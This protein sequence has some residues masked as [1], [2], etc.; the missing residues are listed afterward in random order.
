MFSAAKQILLG[1]VARPHVVG[2]VV[3][4]GLLSL[5]HASQPVH[6][7]ALDRAAVVEQFFAA[8]NQGDVATAM[9]NLTP[10]AN[11]LYVSWATCGR[12][13]PCLGPTAIRAMLESLPAIHQVMIVSNLRISGTVVLGCFEASS[14]TFRAA[15]AQ[16]IVGTF[17]AEV[18]QDKI[19]GF[20]AQTDLTDAQTALNAASPV[21]QVDAAD[22]GACS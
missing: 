2:I 21:A 1:G 6:G 18:P 13:T 11:T 16:R 7:Q 15:G 8:S 12:A 9:A 17:L 10:A 5:N 14:D 19:A 3:S 20:F 4:V 22:T